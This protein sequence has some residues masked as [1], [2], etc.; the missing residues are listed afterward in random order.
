LGEEFAEFGE[1]GLAR[2][3]NVDLPFVRSIALQPDGKILVGS[4]I[5]TGAG[6]SRLAHLALLRFQGDSIAGTVVIFYNTILN[7]FF[8][9]ASPAEQA[10][11]DGGSAGPGWTRNGQ[12]F[13]SGGVSRV[14]RFYGTPGVGP[15]SH[16]YTIEPGECA[17][18]RMDPGWHFESYDFSAT[19]ASPDGGCAGGTVP[20]FRAYNHRFAENDSNH[21]Y[22]GSPNIYNAQLELGWT[23]EGIV[24]C[25][26]K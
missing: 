9:T 4:E 21:R 17:Q 16:F 26:P 14:C 5:Q 24:F 13:K 20:I 6:G 19:P 11:I 25:V 10:A 23:P 2:I 15:N 7:H 12:S 3:E 22:T 8:I 1:A 18:V